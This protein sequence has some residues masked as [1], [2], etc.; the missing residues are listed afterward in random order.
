MVLSLWLLPLTGLFIFNG[1]GCFVRPLFSLVFVQ[2]NS[3]ETNRQEL[4]A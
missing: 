2:E 3:Y 4:E 1:F